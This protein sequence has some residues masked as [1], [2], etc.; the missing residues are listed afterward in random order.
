V[1]GRWLSP[2]Y[3][4]DPEAVPN[5]DL[6]N[7]QSL[8]LYAYVQ[9]N[10]LGTTDSDGHHIEG[11]STSYSWSGDTL[12]VTVSCQAL[13]QLDQLHNNS[14]LWSRFLTWDH[15][16]DPVI[17]RNQKLFFTP[18]FKLSPPDP[19][20]REGIIFP[21]GM[22]EGPLTSTAEEGAASAGDASETTAKPAP[23]Q[24]GGNTITNRIAEGLNKGTGE[25][26]PKREWGRAL[27]A[28]KRDNGLR[29]DVHG[30][31]MTNGDFVVNGETIG[32]IADYIP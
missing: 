2:D 6:S 22:G 14:S 21:L 10:P 32:N 29:N 26:L 23:L 3:S 24:T 7:P 1:S 31:I 4:D 5:A 19:R 12:T 13:P 9:N 15:Y 17:S 18:L 20:L 30:Q 11:C 25:N 28:L 27:E 16:Y 8:N